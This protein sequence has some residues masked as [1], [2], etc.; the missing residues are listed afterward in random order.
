MAGLRKSGGQAESSKESKRVSTPGIRKRTEFSDKLKS[1]GKN[2][3]YK[4]PKKDWSFRAGQAKERTFDRILSGGPQAL[5]TSSSRT[6]VKSMIASGINLSMPKNTFTQEFPR[7][8]LRTPKIEASHTDLTIRTMVRPDPRE[9]TGYPRDC[10]PP[11]NS[12]RSSSAA[13]GEPVRREYRAAIANIFSASL[14]KRRDKAGPN[15]A[16]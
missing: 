16:R 10:P 3:L 2:T 12:D 9:T 13:K 8:D 4:E 5:I 7:P 11:I 6:K 14:L 15:R 1:L